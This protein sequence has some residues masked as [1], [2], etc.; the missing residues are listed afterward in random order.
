M[1]NWKSKVEVLRGKL[2]GSLIAFLPLL[3]SSL[4]SRAKLI[5]YK[6]YIRPM[7]TYAT[8]AWSFISKSSMKRLQAVQNNVFRLIG[9]YNRYTEIEKMQS[10]LETIKLK[11]FMKHLALKLYGSARNSRNKYIKMNWRVPKP[12][13]ILY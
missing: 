7:M 5:M 6:T 2:H 4:P 11:S 8:P 3:R 13:S 9:W 1:M 10:D 12:V